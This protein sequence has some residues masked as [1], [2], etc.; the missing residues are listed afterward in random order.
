[1]KALEDIIDLDKIPTLLSRI[2]FRGPNGCWEWTGGKS[3][4]YGKFHAHTGRWT[5]NQSTHII[6]YEMR[7]GAVPVGKVLDHLCRNVACCNPAHLEAVTTRE[8]TMRGV[9]PA[10]VNAA[11]THCQKCLTEYDYVSPEGYRACRKC[12]YEHVKA[13]RARKKAK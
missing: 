11:K 5:N 13:W 1:M 12:R 2:N 7:N 3:R 8:N 10:P 6:L 9:G 4:G